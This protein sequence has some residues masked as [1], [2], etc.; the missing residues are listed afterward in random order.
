MNH[1]DGSLA[2]IRRA[3]A[4]QDA[5]GNVLRECEMQS[6]EQLG[7]AAMR[8][9]WIA[10]LVEAIINRRVLLGICRGC[11]NAKAGCDASDKPCCPDCRHE[12]TH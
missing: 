8:S 3:R 9:P 1:W 10:G 12:G 6:A 11:G 5:N 2:D 4:E 7:L